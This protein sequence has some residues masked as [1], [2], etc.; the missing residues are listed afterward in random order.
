LH[1]ERERNPIHK[2]YTAAAATRQAGRQAGMNQRLTCGIH[3]VQ[4]LT[5]LLN[6]I[7]FFH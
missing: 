1:F 6:R 4:W 3:R 2:A 7:L 5:A